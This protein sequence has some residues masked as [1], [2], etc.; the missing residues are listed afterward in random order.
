MPASVSVQLVPICRV[1]SDPAQAEPLRAAWSALA[2]RSFRNE[3]S[4]SPDW[5][6]TWWQVYGPLQGRQLRLGFFYQGDR[7]VGL[8][9]LLRR[10]HW[11]H[12]VVPFRRLEFLA[13]G[14]PPDQGIY[15]NH[16]SV[17]AEAGA[18]ELVA[19]ALVRAIQ[20]GAFGDWDETVLPMM[21]ADTPMPGLLAGA[22]RGAGLAVDMTETAQAPYIPLPTTWDAYLRGLSANARRNVRRSLKAL[23][24]RSAGGTR[25]E[26]VQR[27]ADLEMGKSILMK[28]HHQRWESAGQA[29][30][31]RMSSYLRFHDAI[32]RRLLAR[33]DLQLTWLCVDNEPAA[34]LYGMEWSGKV[35]LYQ[36]GRRIDVAGRLRP[37][38]TLLA[39][40]IRK[41]I[42]AGH[43]E[44]D[45]LA[46]DAPFKRQLA[47][48]ARSLLRLRVAF[49]SLVESLRRAGKG[50]LAGLRWLRRH[51]D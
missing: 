7:L 27:F 30:V 48:Q 10:R 39:L 35:Y 4:Q 43:R 42:E 12:G 5:L 40:M 32:M 29:G 25:V 41:A 49:P 36:L 3:L 16:L 8:A 1:V 26:S 20:E 51:A 19:R 11:Y 2:E 44:F 46:D 34:A 23:D 38:A 21:S 31:F 9:P 15:S 14:E 50:C 24:A 13:S 17:L 37:G 33:G 6:L 22:F 45:L 47:P 28:L 18:E